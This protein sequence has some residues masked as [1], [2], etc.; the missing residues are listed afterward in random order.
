MVLIKIE[1]ESIMIGK[2]I[3][4]IKVGDTAEFAKTVSESDVYT[5][6]GVDRRFQSGPYR[7]HVC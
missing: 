2:T 3:D 6:A 1:K 4:E 7:R 5:Y